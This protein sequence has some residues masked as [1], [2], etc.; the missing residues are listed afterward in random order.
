[1]AIVIIL[2]IM[3]VNTKISSIE[4]SE[5]IQKN[6]LNRFDGGIIDKN[7]GLDLIIKRWISSQLDY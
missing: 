1:M 5:M 7:S 4:D 2:S 3:H 6:L